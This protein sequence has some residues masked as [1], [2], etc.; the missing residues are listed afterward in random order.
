MAGEE[1]VGRLAR[2]LWTAL[3]AEQ[4]R[5]FYWVPVLL[6]SGVAIYFALPE[7][8]SLAACLL[9]AA[10]SVGLLGLWR[11]GLESLV[12]GGGLAGLAFHD[13]AFLEME[14]RRLF[15]RC[16]VAAGAASDIPEPGDAR[17]VEVAGRPDG[18]A[19]GRPAALNEAFTAVVAGLREQPSN[20]LTKGVLVLPTP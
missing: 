9:L 14:N 8:P 18:G 6:G 12:V 15:P 20:I 16:W 11:R 17:P 10:L 13:P 5:F 19:A 3:A 4:D 7:E 2:W 1:R